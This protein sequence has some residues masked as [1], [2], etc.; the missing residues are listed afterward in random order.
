MDFLGVAMRR[1][2]LDT[3]L[4]IEGVTV[5]H[6]QKGNNSAVMKKD[7]KDLKGLPTLADLEREVL[8]ECREWGRQR[9]AQR[10]QALADQTGEVFPPVPAQTSAPDAAHRTGVGQ[11]D[12]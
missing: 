7:L 8:T 1:V 2:H 5:P 4:N 12:R 6:R 10:L 3:V 9:L 11:T